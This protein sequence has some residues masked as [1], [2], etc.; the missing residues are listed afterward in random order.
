VIECLPD[1]KPPYHKEK[2]EERKGKEKR[3]K[4]KN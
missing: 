3:K 1:F 4:S 2:K